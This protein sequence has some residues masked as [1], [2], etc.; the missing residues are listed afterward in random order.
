MATE[1]S[2]WRFTVTDYHRMAEA[3]ILTE[4]DRVELIDG[5]IL[6]MSPMGGQHVA[7]VRRLTHLLVGRLSG[8]AYINVQSA[9]RLDEHAEPEPDLAAVREREYGDELPAPDDVL[10]VIEVADTTVRYDRT[11]KL[12]L[13]ARAGIP[14]AWLIDLPGEAIERHTNPLDGQ[15]RLTM[16]ASRGES[17]ESLAVQG[18]V[19]SADDV[20]GRLS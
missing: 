13:Y 2:L 19:L 6:Q 10:L 17:I 7:C 9:V 12:P 18:L 15:Y 11:R 8:K 4:D 14:E 20:L 1:P 3:G 16:R 5:E